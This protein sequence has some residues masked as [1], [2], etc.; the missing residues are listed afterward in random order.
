MQSWDPYMVKMEEPHD[1]DFDIDTKNAMGRMGEGTLK[2]LDKLLGLEGSGG[3]EDKTESHGS[4]QSLVCGGT[5]PPEGCQ[6]SPEDLF[7]DGRP[8][9]E[10]HAPI[11]SGQ[12]R[13]QAPSSPNLPS[14]T[15]TPIPS[16]PP[17]ADWKGDEQT[18][19]QHV[20]PEHRQQAR[21]NF[22]A[23]TGKKP[24]DVSD[25]EVAESKDG[26]AKW[27]VENISFASQA[28]ITQVFGRALADRPEV[29]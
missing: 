14:P 17:T 18:F 5:V 20:T 21:E 10:E 25:Q 23:A 13:M 8:L 27:V 15:E 4:D 2:D 16:G 29:L 6:K 3:N 9:N 12:Y 1:G 11:P 24:E 26:I 28:P 7:G 19:L 22:A